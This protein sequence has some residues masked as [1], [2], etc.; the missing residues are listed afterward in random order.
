MGLVGLDSV[1]RVTA[2]QLSVPNLLNPPDDASSVK[3]HFFRSNDDLW[4][5]LLSEQIRATS[6]VHL[7][8]FWLSEWLPLRPGLFHTEHGRGNRLSAERFLLT[9][10]NASRHAMDEFERILGGKIPSN[11]LDRFNFR[12]TYVYTPWGKGLM[13]EGGIGCIRLKPRRIEVGEVWFMGVTSEP[14]A[15]Q[16]IPVALPSNLYQEAIIE[17]AERGA[18]RCNLT[19]HLK[20]VPPELDPL[21]AELV[22]V[23]QLYVL[24]DQM[25]RLRSDPEPTFVADGAVLV[26]APS[27]GSQDPE[28]NIFGAYVSFDP[29]EGDAVNR[30]ASRLA[31]IYVKGLLGGRV[32]TDFDEQIH[33]FDNAIFSLERVMSGL[34]PESDA[35]HFIRKIAGQ[36]TVQKFIQRIETVNGGINNIQVSGSG[37]VVA[38]AGGV[39]AGPGGAV[40]TGR[41]A[42][43]A[44]NSTASVERPAGTGTRANLA[45]RATKSRWSQAFGIIALLITVAVTVLLLEGVTSI[46]AAGYIL[47]VVAVV[48]GVV[49]ILKQELAYWHSTIARSVNFRSLSRMT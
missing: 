27:L 16:G 3:D 21:Y 13:L 42:A 23:P 39:A 20:I 45:M 12:D 5:M 18:F 41:S 24:V 37:N 47:A 35:E 10:P 7:E 33:R 26:D 43:A 48:V 1:L 31:E 44:D 2:S 34:V 8:G 25:T 6:V 11:L 15:H 30:A 17:I 4:R 29:G 40:A 14:F 19:G 22:G 36:Y 49:P 9:G 38:G 28:D 46:V 32:L